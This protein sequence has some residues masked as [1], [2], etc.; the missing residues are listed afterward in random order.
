MPTRYPH[1][2]PLY[3]RNEQSGLLG[4]AIEAYFDRR[5]GAEDLALVIDY[6]RYWIE[7]PCWR[8]DDPGELAELR[9]RVRSLITRS[10]LDAWL[11]DAMGLGIDPF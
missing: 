6:C 9:Q 10:V 8:W 11:N 7:A 4:Q 3:W 5:E 2:G 1:G